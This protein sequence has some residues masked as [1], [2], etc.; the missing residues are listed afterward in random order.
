MSGPCCN[1]LTVTVVIS[2]LHL[3]HIILPRKFYRQKVK[4]E[5][6]SKRGN[7]YIHTFQRVK[8]LGENLF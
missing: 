6:T 3:I 1:A 7:A 8:K 2:W 5:S 4:Y